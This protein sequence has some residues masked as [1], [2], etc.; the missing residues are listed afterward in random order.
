MIQEQQEYDGW[1]KGEMKKYGV[2]IFKI[3]VA[4]GYNLVSRINLNEQGDIANWRGFD[5]LEDTGVT[6]GLKNLKFDIY[7]LTLSGKVTK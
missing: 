7:T 2:V 3:S 1:H 6:R 4:K 5:C